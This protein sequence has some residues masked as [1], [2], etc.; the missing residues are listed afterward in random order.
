MPI[1]N[2][3]ILTQSQI[4]QRIVSAYPQSCSPQTETP[5]AE[6]LPVLLYGSALAGALG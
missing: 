2:T 5:P 3:F 6:H 1:L 4:G